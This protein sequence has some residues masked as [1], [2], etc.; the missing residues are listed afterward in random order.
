MPHAFGRA[1]HARVRNDTE[2]SDAR[3]LAWYNYQA[4]IF[5]DT[6]V[7]DARFW[8]SKITSDTEVSDARFL[9]WC[10]ATLQREP[11]FQ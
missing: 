4:R 6:E 5:S 9:A 1:H 8:A 2:V 11:S 7:F 3:F 10:S